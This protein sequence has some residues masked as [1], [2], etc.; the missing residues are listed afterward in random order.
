M[1]RN[2]LKQQ[3]VA[4]ELA[5]ESSAAAK[6]AEI[7]NAISDFELLEKFKR[8]V[9]WEEFSSYFFTH[10]SL[11]YRLFRK[12]GLKATVVRAEFARFIADGIP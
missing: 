1:E 10:N 5:K 4:Q 11:L 3:N 2:L 12:N 8:E 9:V 7:D 6:V